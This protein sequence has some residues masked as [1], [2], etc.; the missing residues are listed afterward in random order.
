M[1]RGSTELCLGGSMGCTET[2]EFH[3][4]YSIIGCDVYFYRNVCIFFC[5]V[6]LNTS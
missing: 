2:G 5:F 3:D 4:G 6:A 1:D